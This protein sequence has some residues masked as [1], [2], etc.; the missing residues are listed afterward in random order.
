[1]VIKINGLSEKSLRE[2]ADEVEKLKESYEA[3]NREF[4]TELLKAGIRV[5]S[6]SLSG[7]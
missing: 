7:K 6:E 2:A 4:V 5:G 1:M 3:K